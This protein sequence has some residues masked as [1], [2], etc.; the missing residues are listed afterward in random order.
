MCENVQV[1]NNVAGGVVYGGFVGAL[2]H[3]CYDNS[4]IK[5][6]DNVAHSVKG[7][8]SGAGAYING[9]PTDP[10]SSE[11]FEISDFKAYKTYYTPFITYGKTKKVVVSRMTFIDSRTGYTAMIANKL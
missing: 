7:I 9:D 11:C 4:K 8:K 2:G 6:K 3:K 10:T 1:T 5:F